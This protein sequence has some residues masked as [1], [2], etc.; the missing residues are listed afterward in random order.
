[1]ASSFDIFASF[2]NLRQQHKDHRI[3]QS[4]Q[5]S[6]FRQESGSIYTTFTEAQIQN[7]TM[8][9]K[10]D[11]SI[12]SPRQIELTRNALKAKFEDLF[13]RRKTLMNEVYIVASSSCT[14]LS[15]VA[16]R[17][18]ACK[19]ATDENNKEAEWEKSWND[20]VE[21]FDQLQDLVDEKK[22]RIKLG[23]WPDRVVLA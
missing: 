17:V 16:N 21:I 19:P 5:P 9:I 4:N 7:T 2:E 6:P 18:Q 10:I 8:A 13:S 15:R 1:M 12:L 22:K 20:G 14:K 23:E 3:I 11:A